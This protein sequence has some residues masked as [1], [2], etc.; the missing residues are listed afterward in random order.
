MRFKKFNQNEKKTM[1]ED[2]SIVF[3]VHGIPLHTIMLT[4]SHSLHRLVIT[5]LKKNVITNLNYVLKW[6]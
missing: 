2:I 1:L 5:E 3:R 4:Q 6:L